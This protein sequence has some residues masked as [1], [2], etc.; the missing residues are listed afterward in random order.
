MT[1]DPR[2]H[3]AEAESEEKTHNG[4]PENLRLNHRVALVT[5]GGRGIGRAIAIALARQGAGVAI[6]ARS[7]D[8][9]EVVADEIRALG[10]RASAVECDV[11]E[12]ASI[13]RM[14]ESVRRDFGSL[15]MLVNA[16]GGA[17]K[18]RDLHRVDDATFDVGLQLNLTAVHRTMRAAAPMLFQRPGD[19]AV[20]NIVSIAAATGLPQ[21]SYYSAAKAGVVGLTR[22]AAREWG[23][24][25]VRVNC[26]GPGW[27]ETALSRPLREDAEFFAST[28]ERI[29]LGRWGDPDDV[30]GA[31][32]FLLSDAARYVTGQTLYV[33]G[34]LLA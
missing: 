31:A 34:G 9:L 30:A 1:G 23:P 10:G 16:A 4:V 27:I 28:I 8:E 21:M 7:T 24:R 6:A 20:L 3:R 33:D 14:I 19:A 26:L 11:T 15:H 18:I 13:D 25:G 12:G 32:V 17:H 29:P 5:G 2:S 22:A